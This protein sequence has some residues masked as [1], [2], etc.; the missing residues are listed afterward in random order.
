MGGWKTKS[1]PYIVELDNYDCTK[2]PGVQDPQDMAHPFGWDEISWFAHQPPGY[3][4]YFLDYVVGW[5][6][7]H[8][9]VGHLEMPLM[10]CLCDSAFPKLGRA[11]THFYSA[12]SGLTEREGGFGQE[13]TIARLWGR[14]SPGSDDSQAQA[15]GKPRASAQSGFEPP[16][17]I[18]AM[19]T[20]T[21]S[22]L[23]RVF[24][25]SQ[26]P[27]AA[28]E[29][30]GLVV[31]LAAHEIESTQLVVRA[32]Q[33][34]S[35]G[36]S[37]SMEAGWPTK[38]LHLEWQ[39]VGYV[40]VKDIYRPDLIEPEH[41]PGW[42]PDPLLPVPRLLATAGEACVVW[43]TVSADV[44]CPSGIF[45][46]SVALESA[47]GTRRSIAL[48]VEVFG[49]AL[50][51][52]FKLRTAIDF[53]RKKLS[54]V[55]ANTF[56]V[57]GRMARSPAWIANM[58]RVYEDWMLREL[59]FNPGNIYGSERVPVERLK[60]L[61]K[62]GLNAFN[63]PLP[64]KAQLALALQ[65]ISAPGGY[66]DELQQA[67]LLPLASAYGF[68]ESDDLTTMQAAFEQVQ[69][70]TNGRLPTFTTA[71]LNQTVACLDK[72]H[73]DALC[74]LSSW[75]GRTP[76]KSNTSQLEAEKTIWTYTSLQPYTKQGY[77]N[78][79]LDNTL[80][81]AR[82]LGW[83]MWI[84]NVSGFLYWGVN[85]WNLGYAHR[86]TT[87]TAPPIDAASL[88]SVKLPYSEWNVATCPE[89][90]TDS[91]WCK[92][93]SWLQGD[94][95]LLYAG[96]NGPISSQRLAA[97]RDGLEDA[98]YLTMAAA[99]VGRAAV[100]AAIADV[101]TSLTEHG[102]STSRALET[103]RAMAALIGDTDDR[104]RLLHG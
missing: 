78:L 96:A 89:F 13:D 63:L 6:A 11:P 39:Q 55:Y 69:R 51:T 103:R 31:A 90:P 98:Q 104:R 64:W 88:V 15:I 43:I 9:P 54:A 61:R 79:R 60:V 70:V 97:L 66:L 85:Q 27:S 81:Q 35:V 26:P 24:P 19:Q 32:A 33:N 100:Q 82:L 38:H 23:Q 77:N 99:K 71:H 76:V 56:D 21:V 46:A 7:A 12:S 50:P 84:T 86:N 10:R 68:D 74:P 34:S 53:D 101:V 94:G 80:L 73:V 58:T 57:P 40:E 44:A 17:V 52:V 49:F 62:L 93:L 95:R 29:A 67:G 41:G 1:L 18:D 36:I 65:N 75:L 83:Y 14:P 48:A 16:E 22:S 59:R 25:G 2:H 8:D 3:R 102:T 28:I 4:D 42:W 37:F 92:K 91:S 87:I 72:F 5:L 30:P 47:D 20:W 45:T